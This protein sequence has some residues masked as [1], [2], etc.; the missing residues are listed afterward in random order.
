MMEI[1]VVDDERPILSLWERF[2]ERWGFSVDTAGH[3]RQGLEMA[4]GKHYPLV[5]TDLAMPVL[6]GQEMINTIREEQPEVRFI[7]TTG[8]GTIELAVEMMKSGVHD[9]LTKPINFDHAELVIRKCVESIGAQQDNV[10]LRRKNRDL[11]ELNE[12]KEKFIALTSHELR[13]PVSVISNVVEILRPQLAGQDS[14]ELFS[15]ISRSSA[16]LGEIVAQMHDLSGINSP[17]LE[18]QIDRFKLLPL[19]REI[20]EELQY[21][22]EKR[23]HRIGLDFPEDLA[24]TADRLKFKKVV[25]ELLQNAIKFTQ[26]GGDI[27][28]AASVDDGNRL[29]FAVSD[30]GIGIPRENL[31]KIFHLFYEVGSSMHHHSSK[32]DFLGGGMGVGL[33]IVG[34]IVKAHAG[35]VEVTSEVGRGSCFNVQIPQ[36]PASYDA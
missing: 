15:M 33:S 16:Q 29:N 25:R 27:S 24:V 31:D 17:R 20:V 35:K 12:L 34:D 36:D 5:I 23:K 21:V 11:E 22:L 10:L 19:C 4:R 6:S 32:D 1:L 3:G 13:T 9:F 28:V 14:E 18:L 7:V 30:T 8:Y 26:D 2:M